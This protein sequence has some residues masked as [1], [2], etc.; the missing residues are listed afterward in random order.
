MK[1]KFIQKCNLGEIMEALAE[2]ALDHTGESEIEVS[3]T[4]NEWR[5]ED[6]FAVRIRSRK[7]FDT[8]AQQEYVIIDNEADEFDVMEDTITAALVAI[9]QAKDQESTPNEK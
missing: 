5:G 7:T 6:V 2:R 8:I 9:E 1:R 3:I 4:F